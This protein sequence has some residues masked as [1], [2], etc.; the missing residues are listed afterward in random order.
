MANNLSSNVSTRTM[1]VFLKAF[2]DARVL[3]K[4]V[5]T[6]LIMGAHKPDTGDTIYLKRAHDYAALETSDGDISGSSKNS[7]IAGK[8]A[9]VV[10]NQLTVPLEWTAQEE[11]L[12]L[13]QLEEILAPAARRLV[14]KLETNFADYMMKNCN[15]S[16][17]T[18]GTA[19]DAWSDV[20]D[21]YAMLH[22]IGAPMDQDWNYVINPFTSKG[23]AD[24]QN[25]LNAGDGLV[26]TA[27]ERAQVSSRMAGMKTLV[28]NCLS[29]YT[30]GTASDRAGTVS[31]NP[32]VTYVGAKDTMTQ[33][34]GVAAMSANGTI[35]AGEVVEIT[36]RSRLG[37]ASRL[38][39]LN[40][41]AL[42]K[43]RGV[44]TADVT[45]DGTGAGTIVIAGPA[46]FESGGQ[47]NT[48]DSAVVNGDVITVLGSAS[49]LYQPSM[50]YHPQAFGIGTVKLPK[51]FA[52]DTVAKTQDGISIRVTRYSNGDTDQ[53][54]IRFD[55]LP[56]FGTFNPFLAGQG[57]GS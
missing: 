21:A 6:Q 23:L 19:V 17:G 18:P 45:L 11:A 54:M 28:S 14:T 40:N 38:P 49:T 9:A 31:G 15:L 20:G 7:I 1:R 5:N 2:E 42:V 56:A 26:K 57:F 16:V 8:A 50:F 35:K 33:S 22:A 29:S 25:S 30:S 41:G 55:L 37:L 12:Q 53:N 39:M 52:T 32:T 43:F 34:I 44:V 3:S 4:T 24:V 36:G 47:Y 13:D 46:I 27:W 51:L 48:T 10:Q